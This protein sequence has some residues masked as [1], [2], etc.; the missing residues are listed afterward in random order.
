MRMDVS[1]CSTRLTSASFGVLGTVDFDRGTHLV[2]VVFVV[3][4]NELV[5]PVDSLKPKTT[6][7]L[8]RID[9]LR[10]DPRATLLVD[11]RE[12]DWDQLWWVRVDLEF[13]GTTE[14]AGGWR[15]SFAAKYPQYRPADTIDSFLLFNIGSLRGWRAV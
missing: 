1:E 2:P 15:S 12:A 5:I 11:R 6:R 3:G 13:S 4:R 8:R 9:N 10:A 7:H 14:R